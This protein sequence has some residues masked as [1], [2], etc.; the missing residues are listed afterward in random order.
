VP[1]LSHRS[2]D[3]RRRFQHRVDR[4]AGTFKYIALTNK[5]ADSQRHVSLQFLKQPLNM[6]I[7]GSRQDTVGIASDHFEQG[8]PGE[9]PARIF[10][11]K[12]QDLRFFRRQ[13]Y[14]NH[15]NTRLRF[16]GP[17]VVS[18]A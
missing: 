12:L 18:H 15:G 5:S 9:D 6:H 14:L 16:P 1:Q 10:R 8:I 2:L 17:L 4:S 7:C 3:F 11:E 13:V